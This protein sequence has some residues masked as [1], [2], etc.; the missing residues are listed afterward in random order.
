MSAFTLA[1]GPT[2]STA[3]RNVIFPSTF[4]SMNRSSLPVISPLIRMPGLRDATPFEDVGTLD[5]CLELLGAGAEVVVG[6]NRTCG[7]LVRILRPPIFFSPHK[8]NSTLV[9]LFSKVADRG[10]ELGATQKEQDITA[11]MPCKGQCKVFHKNIVTWNVHRQAWLWKKVPDSLLLFFAWAELPVLP[12]ATI[13]PTTSWPQTAPR[14]AFSPTSFPGR[15]PH[16]ALRLPKRRWQAETPCKCSALAEHDSSRLQQSRCES[17]GPSTTGQVPQLPQAY[18][19]IVWKPDYFVLGNARLDQVVFLKLRDPRA[20]AKPASTGNHNGGNAVTN[21]LRRVCRAVRI[22]NYRRPEAARRRRAR[23]AHQ[24][25][26][27]P[28]Q[29]QNGMPAPN[30]KTAKSTMTTRKK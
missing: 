29:S 1:F 11:L 19:R 8:D 23:P 13:M 15:N 25:P 22:E 21:K 7:I 12:S 4:P 17:G 18:C 3:L 9:F 14:L 5:N 24:S 16:H 28:R 30:T 6:F 26:G 2:V 27:F 10:L 20:R